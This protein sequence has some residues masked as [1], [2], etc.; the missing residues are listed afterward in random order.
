[1]PLTLRNIRMMTALP[2]I[3]S[4]GFRQILNAYFIGHQNLSHVSFS[5][6]GLGVKDLQ[7]HPHLTEEAEKRIWKEINKEKHMAISRIDLWKT[8]PQLSKILNKKLPM[9]A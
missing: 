7:P 8:L 1:M 4:Y 3:P 6:F 2:E 9:V 5:Y